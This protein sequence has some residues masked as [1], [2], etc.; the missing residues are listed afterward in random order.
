MRSK[1]SREE[2]NSHRLRNLSALGMMLGIGCFVL[3]CTQP[4]ASNRAGNKLRKSSQLETPSTS[5]ILAKTQSTKPD[6]ETRASLEDASE[7][8]VDVDSKSAQSE[9]KSP[10]PNAQTNATVETPQQLEEDRSTEPLSDLVAEKQLSESNDTDPMPVATVAADQV[11]ASEHESIGASESLTWEMHV[12]RA[13]ESLESEMPTG[14]DEG[15]MLPVELMR[16]EILLNTLR[17]TSGKDFFP[18]N[19]FQFLHG[20]EAEFWRHQLLGLQLGTQREQI[21]VSSK[22]AAQML[23]EFRLATRALANQSTLELD[24]VAFCTSVYGYADVERIDPC[25]FQADQ[26]VLLYVELENFVSESVVDGEPSGPQG[27]AHQ[28][29]VYET[30]I[31]GSYEIV[32]FERQVIAEHTLPQDKQRCRNP[33]RDYYIAYRI[34]IPLEIA[35]GQ[36]QFELKLSDVKGQKV[37]RATLGFEIGE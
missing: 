30:E 18:D 19:K 14:N 9:S 37:G 10:L 34:F 23:P 4:I 21:A 5:K 13:I 12:Q 6:I 3:G 17:V 22:R 11:G 33:R 24:H 16:R 28:E 27:M 2:P 26:E 32:D 36:Y 1:S 35:A 15:S 20:H 8:P 31:H 25:R 29:L 7:K